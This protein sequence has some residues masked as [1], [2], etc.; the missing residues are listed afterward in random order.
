MNFLERIARSYDLKRWEDD[1]RFREQAMCLKLKSDLRYVEDLLV[2]E[3]SNPDITD[4]KQAEVNKMVFYINQVRDKER[5][6]LM[7]WE[8]AMKDFNKL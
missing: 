7:N 3:A 4:A 2:E 5:S 1:L 8:K 6:Q